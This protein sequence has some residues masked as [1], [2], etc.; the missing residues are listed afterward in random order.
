[1]LNKSRHQSATAQ[2]QYD[3]PGASLR[4]PYK[5][6]IPQTDNRFSESE[7][8]APPKSSSHRTRTPHGSSSHVAV[9]DTSYST[10]PTSTSRSANPSLSHLPPS[11]SQ[12]SERTLYGYSSESTVHA[13]PPPSKHVSSSFNP[14][15]HASSS[16]TNPTST[17]RHEELPRSTAA[18][19]AVPSRHHTQPIPVPQGRS[20]RDV[21]VSIPGAI[22]G[23]LSTQTST[24]PSPRSSTDSGHRNG[25]VSAPAAEHRH[26]HTIWNPYVDTRLHTDS[27][28]RKSEATPGSSRRDDKKLKDKEDMVA[29]VTEAL[30]G[31]STG[32]A[33]AVETALL[34]GQ[35][36]P[37]KPDDASSARRTTSS[38]GS[39][40][41]EP[42]SRTQAQ[43]TLRRTKDAS[44]VMSFSSS[45]HLPEALSKSSRPTTSSRTN[46]ELLARAQA[47]PEPTPK[48]VPIT[49]KTPTSSTPTSKLPVRYSL[50][51]RTLAHEPASFMVLLALAYYF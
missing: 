42:Q 16:R 38:T 35:L 48:P 30:G 15:K 21:P 18:P 26:G 9:T 2:R 6:W 32:K 36:Q 11:Q 40:A 43:P 29:R 10:A 41:L 50:V 14:F 24:D 7:T 33:K 27:M 1:M 13:P 20:S 51:V 49:P 3:I 28:S 34:Q 12:R 5:R 44:H 47:P 8:E 23:S 25:H 37:V 46:P 31:G 4:G 45:T 22:F 19:A 17:A 39:R